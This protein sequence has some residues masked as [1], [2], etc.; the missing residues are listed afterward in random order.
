MKLSLAER[1]R[2][3]SMPVTES[4]CHLWLGYIEKN[5]Y[6]KISVD[7]KREWAHRVSYRLVNGH[8]PEGMEIDHLCR[9]RCCVNPLHLEA[10]THRTNLMRGQG[11]SAKHAVK[12]HC[13]RGHEFSGINMRIDGSKRQCRICDNIRQ[14][15][16]RR[17]AM[18]TCSRFG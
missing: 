18:A 17:N 3:Y 6:A 4:G 8:I 13:Y 5:G 11:E 1:F 16:R 14:R 9:V 15:A 12:T 7:G 2:M 10:V